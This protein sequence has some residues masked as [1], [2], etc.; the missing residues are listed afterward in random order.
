[1]KKHLLGL[2]FPLLLLTTAFE[3]PFQGDADLVVAALKS[4]NATE[5]AKHFAVVV[6]IKFLDAPEDKIV[7][8]EKAAQKLATFFSEYKIKG[9]ERTAQREIGNTMYL[10]GK[11]SGASKNYNITLMLMKKNGAPYHIVTLRVN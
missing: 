5:V 3:G 7:A 11:I 10:T 2:L 9:F 6:D 1:M 8:S 4:G